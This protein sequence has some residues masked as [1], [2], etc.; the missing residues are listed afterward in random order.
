[1]DQ[2]PDRVRRPNLKRL[3]MPSS[4]GQAEEQRQPASPGPAPSPP[5]GAESAPAASTGK[6]SGVDRDIL[7]TGAGCV[8]ILFAGLLIAG[9]F[10]LRV[11]GDK[12]TP[13]PTVPVAAIDPT[14]TD[15]PVPTSTPTPTEVSP[16]TPLPTW[17]PMGQKQQ[18]SDY[19]GHDLEYHD[20]MLQVGDF[21]QQSIGDVDN[22]LKDPQ[23]DNQNWQYKIV[24]QTN[25]WSEFFFEVESSIPPDRY[26]EFHQNLTKA[27]SHMNSAADDITYALEFNEPNRLDQ[28]KTEIAAGTKMLNDAIASLRSSA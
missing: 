28:A 2:E 3:N 11:I 15:T 16:Y 21:M 19:R 4:P 17:T 8:L 25:V 14:P 18:V 26:Q 10:A 20:D 27:L 23:P 6:R 7:M 12:A 9:V 24:T 1:M 5:S 22:L 13:V